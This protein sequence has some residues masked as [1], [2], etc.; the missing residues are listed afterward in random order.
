[1]IQHLDDLGV[2]LI[3]SRIRAYRSHSYVLDFPVEGWL[4]DFT[5][6]KVHVSPERDGIR[7]SFGY[8]NTR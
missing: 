6:E 8:F 5:D 4:D 1:M 7:V 2:G 3:G